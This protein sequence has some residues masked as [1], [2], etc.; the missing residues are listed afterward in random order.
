M[1]NSPFCRQMHG[2]GSEGLFDDCL[3]AA[4][5]YKAD[6]AI[7]WA[8]VGCRESNATVRMLREHLK[9]KAGIPTLVLDVDIFDPTFIG[10][11]AIKDKLE[12]FFE[13]MDDLK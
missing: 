1:F 11:E 6:G 12:G 8:H 10:E 5:D 3:N 2:P 7:F 13:L 4:I 9:E